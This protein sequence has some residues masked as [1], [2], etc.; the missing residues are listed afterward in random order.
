MKAQWSYEPKTHLYAGKYAGKKLRT[1]IW[2]NKTRPIFLM[3]SKAWLGKGHSRDGYVIQIKDNGT[4][5]TLREEVAYTK[6]KAMEIAKQM[7]SSINSEA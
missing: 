5:S 6:V 2:R 1:E 4:K 3:V 7:R